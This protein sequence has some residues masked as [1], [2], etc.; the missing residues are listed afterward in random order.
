MVKCVV[1]NVFSYYFLS[2]L[3]T[4]LVNLHGGPPN[5]V[6]L[7]KNVDNIEYFSKHGNVWELFCKYC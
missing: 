5:K 6:L 7:W 4:N 2:Y 3:L 1:E